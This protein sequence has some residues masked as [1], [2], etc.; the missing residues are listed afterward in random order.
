MTKVLHQKTKKIYLTESVHDGRM[1][2][3]NISQNAL[4]VLAEYS[5]PTGF[6]TF[7]TN[8]NWDKY[9]KIFVKTKMVS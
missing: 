6:L 7:T 3:K 9:W 5:A 4:S 2:L 1:H 8:S